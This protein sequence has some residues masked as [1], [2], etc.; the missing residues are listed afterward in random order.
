MH[1]LDRRCIFSS[2]FIH[3]ILFENL[4]IFF[5]IFRDLHVRKLD[6]GMKF[7]LILSLFP[8]GFFSCNSPKGEKCPNTH[9]LDVESCFIKP[10]DSLSIHLTRLSF[11][12]ENMLFIQYCIVNATQLHYSFPMNIGLKNLITAPGHVCHL[13]MARLWLR[14]KFLRTVV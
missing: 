7:F 2:F 4:V 9:E 6:F 11:T 10:K 1:L 8:L 5:M 13:I 3:L 12:Q 14:K